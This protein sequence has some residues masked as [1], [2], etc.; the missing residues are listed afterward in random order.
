MLE[1]NTLYSSL[2]CKVTLLLPSG[3]TSFIL[4][5]YNT[6]FSRLFNGE[7]AEA[8]AGIID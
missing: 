1:Y 6:L 3:V 8:D 5:K 7:P 4:L 2:I